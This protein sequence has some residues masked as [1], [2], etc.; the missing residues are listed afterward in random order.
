M[1]VQRAVMSRYSLQLLQLVDQ[2]AGFI[3]LDA[4]GDPWLLQRGSQLVEMLRAGQERE[5]SLL[6]GAIDD[7][8][9]SYLNHES[10]NQ[11]VGVEHHAHQAVSPFQIGRAHV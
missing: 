11:N 8:R 10:G 5:V 2:A 7:G 9:L 1:S 6:P 4:L 3:G